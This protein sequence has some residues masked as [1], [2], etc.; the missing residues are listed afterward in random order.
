MCDESDHMP[1]RQYE[2]MDIGT[3]PYKTVQERK[4][5]IQEYITSKEVG[6]SSRA[7]KVLQIESAQSERVQMEMEA[8]A[9]Q[10][11]LAEDIQTRT[12]EQSNPILAQSEQGTKRKNA[13]EGEEGT[14]SSKRIV[15][16]QPDHGLV[17]LHKPPRQP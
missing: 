14:S 4:D 9:E 11:Q 8:E 2:L 7:R 17:V 5:A 6:E 3:N 16:E 13:E 10:Q 1:Q 12:E 15:I